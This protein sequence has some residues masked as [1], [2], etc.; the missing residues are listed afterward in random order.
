MDP[1]EARLQFTQTLDTLSSSTQALQKAIT[2]ALK[3]QEL[4]ED[5]HSV[6]L[7]ILD[8]LDVNP[9]INVLYFIEALIKTVVGANR[10]GFPPPYLANLERDFKLILEKVIGNDLVNLNCCVDVLREVETSYGKQN[11]DLSQIYEHL[12]LENL[13]P[14]IDEKDGFRAAWSFL[15]SKKRQGIHDRLKLIHEPF[16]IPDNYNEK[17][18]RDQILQRIENDRERHKRFKETNWVVVRPL[19]KLEKP[20]FGKIWDEFEALDDDDYQELKELQQIA[21]ESYQV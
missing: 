3:N 16:A 10:D 5:F 14:K 21:R 13:G 15:I 18:T 9:R 6:I 2:L 11:I 1:F 20:E 4:H 12:T 19:G 7:E 17:L 8:R